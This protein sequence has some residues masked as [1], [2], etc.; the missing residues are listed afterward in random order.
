MRWSFKIARLAGIDIRI[1]L[2]FLLFLAWI[3]FA[4]YDQGGSPAAAQAVIFI[5]A[6]FGCVLLHEF[7][8]AFAAR[9]F[10]VRTPDITLLPIGGVARL[11]RM[12][13]HPMQELIVALA[14]PAVNV[15]I[16]IVLILG[17]GVQPDFGSVEHMGDPAAG[18]LAKLAA[19]NV[20]LVFFNLIPAFPMDGGRV[21]RALLAMRMNYARATQIAAGIGQALAFAF[22]LVGVFHNPML[23]F[24]A[25]FIYFGAQQEATLAAIKDL[26]RCVSVYD[27]MVSPVTRLPFYATID[28][29]VTALMRTQQ[30]AFPVVDSTERVLGMLTR[31]DMIAAW[32]RYG[33]D[34]Q[35][36]DVM[37][38]D[39]PVVHPYAP[40]SEAFSLMQECGCPA[41]PVADRFGRLVGLITVEQAGELML[42]NSLRPRISPP[43]WRHA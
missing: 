43:I 42:I 22:G 39:V 21:L 24:I 11:Q 23:I 16:A 1:H 4:Y 6:L 27:V 26:A 28:N 37:Q 10:G 13:E 36:A 33:A 9:F 17:F 3:A 41:L 25:L 20:S 7:G 18:Q 5:L 34:T 32:K 15:L 31:D 8:H 14:G 38:R 29:A 40:L 19:V 35:V 12:P 30:P 2:T